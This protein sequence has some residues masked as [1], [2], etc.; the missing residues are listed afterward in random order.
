MEK[1][2]TPLELSATINAVCAALSNFFVIPAQRITGNFKLENGSI[3]LPNGNL[4][5]G[6]RVYIEPQKDAWIQA[7]GSHAIASKLP[8]YGAS[9]LSKGESPASN[10][11][12][13]NG[14]YDGNGGVSMYSDDD[15]DI[16]IHYPPIAK[17]TGQYLYTLNGLSET[18]DTDGNIIT[19]GVYDEWNG[20]IY[21]Q[22]INRD[23]L[24]ICKRIHA[25]MSNPK[26][27]PSAKTSESVIGV[28]SWTKAKGTDGKPLT[29]IDVH[30]DEL[31]HWNRP[32]T[33]VE[34]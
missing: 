9:D 21:G 25:Y 34:H 2:I 33:G 24:E 20:V 1:T 23:F 17:P 32:H 8:L 19:E 18:T 13:G 30:W 12:G 14:A 16:I 5:V 26:N 27:Y 15:N 3:A 11:N 31:K 28:Y 4:K 22:A 6:Q 29:A 7:T 10:G